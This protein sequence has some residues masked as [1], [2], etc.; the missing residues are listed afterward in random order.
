MGVDGLKGQ[1]I[2][3]LTRGRFSDTQEGQLYEKLASERLV[4][5]YRMGAPIRQ[6]ERMPDR[7]AV[8]LDCVIYA[9]AVRNLVSANVDR[10]AEKVEA[11]TMPQRRATVTISKWLRVRTH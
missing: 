10:R 3:R 7:R 8:S 9:M 6:W 1:L 4:V 5:R 11:V 2:N